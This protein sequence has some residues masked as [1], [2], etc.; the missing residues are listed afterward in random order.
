MDFLIN[1][2][3]PILLTGFALFMASFVFWTVLPHHEDDFQQADD[4]DALMEAL[5]RLN[6]PAGKYLFPFIRHAEM[7]DEAKVEKYRQGPRGTLV[8]WDMPNMGRNLGLTFT[9]FLAIAAVTAYITWEALGP[10]AGF[11]KVFQ[12][13]GAIGIL[14]HCSSGQLNAVW[15]PRRTLMDFLDGIAYGLVTG[16]IFALL[17]PGELPT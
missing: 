7:K 16:L 5:G 17:W 8:L 15:F 13:A 6:L 11:W 12:I 10:G 2:W 14:V 1:L 9:L 3:L 4:E